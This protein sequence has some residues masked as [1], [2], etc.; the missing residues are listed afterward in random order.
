MKYIADLAFIFHW[1][2]EVIEN[3]EYHELTTWHELACER[4]R[5][6]YNAQ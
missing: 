6:A 3:L 4:M 1:T 5:F 2:P